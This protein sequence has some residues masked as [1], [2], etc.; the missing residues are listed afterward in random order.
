M[1]FPE[2]FKMKNGEMTLSEIKRN[3]RDDYNIE[4]FA[5]YILKNNRLT[6]VVVVALAVTIMILNWNMSHLAIATVANGK[7][8]DI[9]GNKLLGLFKLYGKWIL[10]VVC[11][12]ESIKSGV[13]GD[14]KKILSIV[15]KYLLIYLSL[16]LVPELFDMITASF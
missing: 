2:F 16:F 3:H 15:V 10:L 7:G 11:S 8:I 9:L 6:K 5:N 4:K 12:L 1:S 14:S 13:N